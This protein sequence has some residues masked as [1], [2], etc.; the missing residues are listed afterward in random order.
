MSYETTHDNQGL[1]LV[2][3]LAARCG[4]GS[5]RLSLI[6]YGYLR[7]KRTSINIMRATQPRD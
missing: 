4:G 7:R 6:N 1:E 2:I 3:A 5:A